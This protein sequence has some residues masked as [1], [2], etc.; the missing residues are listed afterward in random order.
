MSS[1]I[2]IAAFSAWAGRILIHSH[3]QYMLGDGVTNTMNTN[4]V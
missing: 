4:N 1:N 3:L 2:F